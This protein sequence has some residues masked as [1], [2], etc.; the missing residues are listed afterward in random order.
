MLASPVPEAEIPTSARY[1]PRGLD[2]YHCLGVENKGM[3]FGAPFLQEHR[4]T[5]SHLAAMWHANRR[6]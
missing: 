1:D 6:D 4:L 3:F 5:G 2:L